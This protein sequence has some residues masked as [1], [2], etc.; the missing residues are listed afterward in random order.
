MTDIMTAEQRSRCMSHI[1]SRDTKP[2]MLV[3]KFLFSKGLRYRINVRSL[4]GTP[5][6][7]FRKCK[8]AVF[9]N[10]CFWHGHEG[11]RYFRMPSSNVEFWRG[12]IERNVARD[13]SADEALLAMG[14]RVIRVWECELKAKV[15]AETLEG[16]YRRIVGSVGYGEYDYG[17]DVAA[18]GEEL[19]GN[20][21]D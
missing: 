19:Y 4:P 3:R 5:D 10:G 18:E 2:E 16:L 6:L 17:I 14:W 13:R 15:R 9:V 1:R 12:K 11:C 8:T 21:E 7:V 20:I